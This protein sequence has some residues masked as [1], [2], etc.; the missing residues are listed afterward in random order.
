MV[1]GLE[2]TET[3]A[4]I[5]SRLVVNKAAMKMKHRAI[6]AVV[7]QLRTCVEKRSRVAEA[8]LR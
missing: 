3:I 7:E 1:N 4:Q 8:K 6:E 2:P 5:S